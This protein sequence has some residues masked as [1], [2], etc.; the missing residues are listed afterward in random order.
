MAVDDDGP[1]LT[2]PAKL[3][4]DRHGRVAV[5]LGCPAGEKP[6][7]LFGTA[8]LASVKHGKS[9]KLAAP[10][11]FSARGGSSA[12]LSFRLKRSAVRKL[13]HKPH[14]L[15]VVLSAAAED[16]AGNTATTSAKL[17]LRRGH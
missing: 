14:K 13:K 3:K 15:R 4:S 10:Q 5:T 6:G 9:H 17:K 1:A 8:T 12:K 7:C 2:L 16:A 11:Q